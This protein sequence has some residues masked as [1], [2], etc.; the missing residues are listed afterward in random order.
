M[1]VYVHG[2]RKRYFP[3]VSEARH[4]HTRLQEQVRLRKFLRGSGAEEEG[5]AYGDVGGDGDGDERDGGS[6]G[7]GGSSEDLLAEAGVAVVSFLWPAYHH[8]AS[9]GRARANANGPAAQRLLTTL[10]ALRRRRQ[11]RRIPKRDDD[12]LINGGKERDRDQS[13]SKEGKGRDVRVRIF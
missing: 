3:A 11:R 6:G 13:A 1:V 5:A 2:F 8:S 12:Q 7:S 10:R 9:Y 4:I